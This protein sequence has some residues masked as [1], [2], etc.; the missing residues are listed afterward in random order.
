MSFPSEN[1][2]KIYKSDN[3]KYYM[4]ESI[5]KIYTLTVLLVV[6]F[7]LIGVLYTTQNTT[8]TQQNTTQEKETAIYKELTTTKKVYSNKNTIVTDKF[9]QNLDK[10][11]TIVVVKDGNTYSISKGTVLVDDTII[12][13]SNE[14]SSVQF[15]HSS[16]GIIE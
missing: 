11:G 12:K 2:Q 5:L 10:D 6:V 9:T 3:L 7:A 1:K 16:R 13:A 15:L 4:A 8:Q 14:D